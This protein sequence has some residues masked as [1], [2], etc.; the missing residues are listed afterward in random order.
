V[1]GQSST[2]RE[3]NATDT[4]G[5]H[6]EGV[7]FNNLYGVLGSTAH[8]REPFGCRAPSRPEEERSKEESPG[9]ESFSSSS[10]P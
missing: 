10:L 3:G 4:R 9:I 8:P 5:P 7:F 6:A 2:C 1:V